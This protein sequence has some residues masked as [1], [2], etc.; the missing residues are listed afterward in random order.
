L[1]KQI[2]GLESNAGILEE[3]WTRRATATV[4]R[5]GQWRSYTTGASI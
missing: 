1:G 5:A 4:L 2:P 3:P